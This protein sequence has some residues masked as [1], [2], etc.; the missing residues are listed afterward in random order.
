MRLAAAAPA[1][2][3]PR[4]PGS[5]GRG[6]QDAAAGAAPAGAKVR[7][8]SRTDKPLRDAAAESADVRA[9]TCAPG[10]LPKRG[11]PASAVE[12][13]PPAGRTRSVLLRPEILG[14]VGATSS[15]ITATMAANSC[16][17]AC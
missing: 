12:G 6:E 8:A 7:G 2:E 9:A 3:A 14:G 1:R 5:I 10:V 13:G 17:C 16:D 11:E 4:R 15:S